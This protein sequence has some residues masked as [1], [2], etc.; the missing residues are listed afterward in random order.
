MDEIVQAALKKWPNVPHCF[1]WLALDA[2][3]TWRMRDERC[4][5]LNLRGDAIRNQTLAGFINRNYLV[6]ERGRWY[7]QN[8]PQRVY[9]DLETAPYIVHTT[10][11]RGLVFHTDESVN[12]VN[13]FFITQAGQLLLQA[14]DRF[15]QVDD[16][17]LATCFAGLK[18]DGH[19]ATD[20]E[21][22]G[23]LDS[24]AVGQNDMQHFSIDMHFGQDGLRSARLKRGELA[25]LMQAYGY[26]A[27]PR[28]ENA[29]E[30]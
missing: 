29:N 28:Q 16:R 23:L 3:G 21:V 15:A 1:G 25:D 13:T 30:V 20:E 6:D 22:A 24:G 12:A 14:G 5:A 26:N 18:R 19:A 27:R 7:F 2:R 17:D 8:G 9:V 11:D 10:H 4:Q